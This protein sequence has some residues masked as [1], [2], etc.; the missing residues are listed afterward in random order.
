MLL[1]YSKF[2]YLMFF[3]VF[4]TLDHVKSFES[5]FLQFTELSIFHFWGVWLVSLP[6]AKTLKMNI[7]PSCNEYFFLVPAENQY[8]Q[9]IISLYL[10]N[11]LQEM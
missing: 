6:K 11:N 5:L 10:L 8:E 1:L 9:H 3:T 4:F 7:F 2:V